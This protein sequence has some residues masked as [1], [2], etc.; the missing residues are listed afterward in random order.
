MEL[1]EGV[2]MKDGR[3]KDEHPAF[4]LYCTATAAAVER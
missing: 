2:Y 3:I 4:I 1:I